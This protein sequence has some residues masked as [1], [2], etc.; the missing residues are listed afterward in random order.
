MNQ[1]YLLLFL[2][3]IG[4]GALG[5]TS[6]TIPDSYP[7]LNAKQL[8]PMKSIGD[9]QLV[10]SSDNLDSD[11]YRVLLENNTQIIYGI[12]TGVLAD[13]N[14]TIIPGA[15]MN[16][17][18]IEFEDMGH[19]ETAA[20]T[21][22]HVVT[23]TIS[24]NTTAQIK[25]INRNN[26]SYSSLTIEGLTNT[27]GVDFYQEF[28]FWHIRQYTIMTKLTIPDIGQDPHRDVLKFIDEMASI[29]SP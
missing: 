13:Y 24:T 29:Y 4:I 17:L 18:I 5:C 1:R 25:N 11:F 7:I 23:K 28:V 20:S 26:M 12:K 3:I 19:A 10:S 9:Y 2:L 16:I 8:L 15:T 22:Q 6:T 27:Y 14:S 21:L